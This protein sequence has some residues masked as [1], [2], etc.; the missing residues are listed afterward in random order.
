MKKIF[1]FVIAATALVFGATACEKTSEGLT[2]ITYYPVISLQGDSYM[3]VDKGS[4]F[5]DPGFIA[6]LNGEDYSSQVSVSSNVDTSTSGIYTVSYSAVNEDGFSA[7][8]NRTVVVLDPNDPIEGFYL[9]DF[10]CNRNGTAYGG[11]YEVLIIGEGDGIYAV[12]D[13]LAGWY[14]V[15]A[16]YGTDYAMQG[17]IEIA[18]DGTATMQDSYV[19]GWGDSADSFEGS[20]DFDNGIL[21]YTL[22]YAGSYNFN[23]TLVKE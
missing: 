14:C 18:D 7:T 13:L 5:V 19:P 8:V 17:E 23:V 3:I 12:D 9:T 4:A 15:R 2:G 16:G 22:V 21:T 6:E 10:S 1:Y 11:A 20:Y